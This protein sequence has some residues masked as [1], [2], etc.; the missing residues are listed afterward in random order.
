MKN[1]IPKLCAATTLAMSGFAALN[2]SADEVPIFDKKFELAPPEIVN[3]FKPA[4]LE[5]VDYSR[6]NIIYIMADDLGYADV[7]VYGQTNFITPRLDEM[8]ANG[9]RFSQFYAGCHICAPSRSCVISGQHLGRADIRT[10]H[11]DVNSRQL[12]NSPSIG[13]ALKKVGYATAFLG[14]AGI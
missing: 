4:P 5:K 13:K 2:C 1:S 10:L 11:Y 12:P 3:V 14:K 6:P 8:A 9:M 7:G